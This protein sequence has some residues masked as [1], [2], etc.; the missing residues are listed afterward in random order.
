MRV[1]VC[2]KQRE[3]PLL[4]Q[5]L[6]HVRFGSDFESSSYLECWFIYISYY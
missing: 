2:K 1:Y 6:L 5:V 4:L 3:S